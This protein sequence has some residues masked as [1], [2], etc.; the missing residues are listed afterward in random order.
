VFEIV[1]EGSKAVMVSKL[2]NVELEVLPYDVSDIDGQVVPNTI[3]C[4][5]ILPQNSDQLKIAEGRMNSL[6]RLGGIKQVNFAHIPPAEK[7][8]IGWNNWFRHPIIPITISTILTF[9][10]VYLTLLGLHCHLTYYDYFVA[11]IGPTI[12]S[13]L[14]AILYRFY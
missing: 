5:E 4:E 11:L 1:F 7:M 14:L 13:V 12:T 10:T 3:M 2:N 6:Y 9:L 8:K